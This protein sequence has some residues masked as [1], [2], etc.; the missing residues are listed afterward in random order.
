MSKSFNMNLGD[1]AF[2]MWLSIC[3]AS[4]ATCHVADSC[5]NR[6]GDYECRQTCRATG[7]KRVTSH[8]CECQAVRR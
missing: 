3:V 1:F 5:E 4:C 2:F 8:T 7:V 6:R